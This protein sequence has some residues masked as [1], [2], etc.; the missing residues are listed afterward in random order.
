MAGAL[1]VAAL[2]SPLPSAA[3]V[4]TLEAQAGRLRYDVGSALLQSSS[5][6]LGVRYSDPRSWARVTL[7]VPLEEGDAVW[8]GAGSWQRL[9]LR[10]GYL[11]FGMDLTGNVFGFRQRV[12]SGGG[13][14]G[15]ITAS[16]VTGYALAG[17]ALPLIAVGTDRLRVEAR[18]GG[19]R[20][21]SEVESDGSART[22]WLGDAQLQFSPTANVALS[23]VVRRF[24]APAADYTYAGGGA[25]LLAGPAQ[26]WAT[27]GRWLGEDE[28]AVPWAAGVT[29]QLHDRA[30]VT[31]S[32]RRD[33][34]D[35]LYGLPAR[36]T[37]NVG[38]AYRMAGPPRPAE[39]VPASYVDGVAT[40]V[41]PAA[42]VGGQPSVGG[43]FNE[44][45]PAPMRRDGD[46]WTY[47][48]TVDPGVYQYAFV[49]QDGTWFVPESVP[50]R[51]DDGMGGHVAVLVV[52]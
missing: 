20:Y 46:V 37:W 15:G 34:I 49:A 32:G 18:A 52:R 12:E 10:R 36:T 6:G 3:Q 16:T 13:L 31:F 40:I 27:A 51:R 47:A 14:L 19:S 42:D 44:W 33:G 23:G 41:V 21:Y 8:G 26:L 24:H 11:T 39:P 38:L 4:W 7:G 28:D 48:V 2:S 50:G 17:E 22:V 45:T 43:D 5:L 29:L 30:G 35:P 1:C 9:A 25:F